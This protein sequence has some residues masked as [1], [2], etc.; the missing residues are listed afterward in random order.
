MKALRQQQ[1]DQIASLISHQ[2]VGGYEFGTGL[3]G[4]SPEEAAERDAAAIN[5]GDGWTFELSGPLDHW[6]RHEGVRL[7]PAELAEA[8]R[9]AR[10]LAE[11]DLA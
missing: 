2:I 7:G 5:A 10:R 4:L 11:D 6:I 3:S 8:V 1:I 9:I